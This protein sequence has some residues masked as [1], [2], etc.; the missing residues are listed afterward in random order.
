MGI[1]P[2]YLH[3]LKDFLNGKS[4]QEYDNIKLD[5]L[6]VI[7]STGSVLSPD[8]FKFTYKQIKQ[9]IMLASITGGT[10]IISLFAGGC[11]LK[12][13]VAGELQCKCLGMRVEAW[14]ENGKPVLDSPGDLVC[15][16]PF[17]CM[18]IYFLNDPDGS[19]YRRA[20]FS[21]FD[22]VWHHGDYCSIS[23]STGGLVMLGRSD[24]TLNPMGVRFGSSELYNQMSMFERVEDSLAISYKRVQDTDE[25]LVLFVKM[26]DG[27]ELSEDLVKEIKTEIR[28]HLSPRHVPSIVLQCPDIPVPNIGC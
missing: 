8:L 15:T 14:N 22:N 20:Y 4:I 27:K 9:N 26:K 1:S 6:R 23:A 17:P 5:R 16:A 12:P 21:H 7:T 3:T 19:L 11:P 28:N 24:G 18:P 2:K 13:V 10:D 25:R